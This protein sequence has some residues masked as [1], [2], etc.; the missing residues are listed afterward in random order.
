MGTGVSYDAAYYEGIDRTAEMAAPIVAP[1]IVEIAQPKSIV[2][3]GCASGQWLNAFRNL[4]VED[5]LGIDGKWIDAAQLQIPVEN[6]ARRNLS[7]PFEIDRQFDVAMTLEVAEHLPPES[8]EDFVE[9]LVRLAPLIVFSAAIPGQGGTNHLNEQWPDY[10]AEL[11]GRHDYVGFDLIRPQ[12]W[13][14][15]RVPVWYR[16]NIGIFARTDRAAGLGGPGIRPMVHP[17]MFGGPPGIR[18]LFR[19]LPGA[20]RRAVRR[21]LKALPP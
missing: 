21:R 9:S 11:F 19:E 1:L 7:Q 10:W 4:G 5:F 16:Q 17:E 14:D 6:F 2:D 3:V 12:I 13:D 15:L 20:V 18:G 8:A